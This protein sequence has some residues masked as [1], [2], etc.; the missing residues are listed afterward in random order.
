VGDTVPVEQQFYRGYRI[1]LFGEG[2][3]WSFKL[4]PTKVDLPL[5]KRTIFLNA[6]DAKPCALTVAKIEIDRLWGA[7]SRKD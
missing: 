3:A 7:K 2:S 4:A 6:A 1:S 5:L